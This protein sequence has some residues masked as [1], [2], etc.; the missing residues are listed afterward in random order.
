MSCA[1]RLKACKILKHTYIIRMRQ[2]HHRS[3]MSL[4]SAT[5]TTENTC[6][7]FTVSLLQSAV[8]EGTHDGQAT[9]MRYDAIYRY[10]IYMR[11]DAI[12]RYWTYI[13]TTSPLPPSHGPNALV[14]QPGQ[15]GLCLHRISFVSLP[16]TLLT[17][18][19]LVRTVKKIRQ[20]GVWSCFQ[21]LGGLTPTP[22]SL[23]LTCKWAHQVW[24]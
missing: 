22:V 5:V 21:C 10:W 18:N 9:Y 14:A 6:L 4:F 3:E 2:P 1:L 20:D 19:Q 11:Y 17:C 23:R 7:F 8:L 13:C 24:V 16:V 15:T 12:Y